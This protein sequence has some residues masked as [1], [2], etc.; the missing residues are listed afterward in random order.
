MLIHSLKLR[1]RWVYLNGILSL[2]KCLW[3]I[4]FS[5]TALIFFKSLLNV[6]N[7]VSASFFHQNSCIY[8]GI[9]FFRFI[10]QCSISIINQPIIIEII[11]LP[12]ILSLLFSLGN[13][14]VSISKTAFNIWR[15]WWTYWLISI[16]SSTCSCSSAPSFIFKFIFTA[17][18]EW[19]SLKLIS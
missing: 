4:R 5:M 3:N 11:L 19:T 15:V 6:L 8:L 2:E 14:R 12:C 17:S 13:A 9:I 18:S 7:G 1:S 10:F 16:I